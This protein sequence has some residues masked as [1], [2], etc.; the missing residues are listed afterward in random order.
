LNNLDVAIDPFFTAEELDQLARETQ[1]VRREGKLNGSLFFDL[2]VFHNENLKAQSLND[3]SVTLKDIY[4]IEIRKQSLHERFNQY[5][6]AFLK[7]ALEKLLHQQLELESTIFG[8]L[9]GFN[10]ILIKDSTS[11]Q[12]DASLAQYYGGSGGAGSEASVRIQFE[13]DIVSGSINDLSVT[14]FN[15]QDAKDSLATIE[16]TDQDDLII[17]DLAY[18]GLQV[19]QTIQ[20]KNA[21]YLCRAN[22]IVHIFQKHLDRYEKIDFVEITNYMKTHKI[23][24][25]EKEVYLGSK[26]KFKTRLILYLLPEEEYAKRIRKAQKN[27]KKKSR[28]PLSKEYKA[29]A[30]L[31]LFITNASAEQIPMDKAWD[32]YRLRWQI[33]LIF[34]IWKSICN[35][36]KVK[37]VKKHRLEC[38]IYAKLVLIVLSWQILWRTARKLFVNE[39]KALSFF[40]ASKTLIRRKLGDLREIIMLGEGSMQTFMDQFYDL[41]KTNHILEKRRK[42]PTSMQRMLSCLDSEYMG[43]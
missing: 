24:C 27:N 25:L 2:I 32:F 14:A 38:Y 22:P 23:D 28:K 21:F 12:I 42:E 40:K 11:F 31:N 13:Y 29:R 9:K 34:K 20:I 17:R 43:I 35:I 15:Q 6:L 5:A 8:D 41:S 26:E 7:E 19:L 1:F 10:R 33:E 30:A 37:K 18:M 39:G 36:E 3:M 4:G 16:L